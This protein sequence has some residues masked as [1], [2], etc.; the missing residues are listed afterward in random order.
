MGPRTLSALVCLAFLGLAAPRAEAAVLKCKAKDGTITYTQTT[1]PP[2]TT[3]A[4]FPEDWNPNHSPGTS[5]GSRAGRP[6]SPQAVMFMNSAVAC[7]EDDDEAGCE[8]IGE[9]AIFCKPEQNWPSKTCVALREGVQAARDQVHM[10]DEGSKRRLR[11]LCASGGDFACSLKE[12]P[13]DMFI[14]GSDEQVRACAARAK[15]PTSGTWVKVDHAGGNGTGT[16]VCLKK[17]EMTSSIGEQLSFRESIKVVTFSQG[18]TG[19]PT[20]FAASSL[21]DELFP[22]A[23][24]AATAG[25]EAKTS[26]RRNDAPPPA[27]PPGQKK[28]GQAV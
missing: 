3:N 20:R 2:G 4:D 26:P 25:C 5:S 10:T 1:C 12:C 27:P 28:P 13:M 9:A 7:L 18:G 11:Q 21:P 8:V 15:L 23:N 22:T 16:Y 6:S 17:V 19:S 24:A 14:K